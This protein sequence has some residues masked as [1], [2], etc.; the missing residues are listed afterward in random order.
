MAQNVADTSDSGAATVGGLGSIEPSL[1][2]ALPYFLA[3][4]IFPLVI[5]A[6]IHGGWWL[7]LPLAFYWIASLFDARLGDDE[8]N[9]D[10]ERTPEDRLLWYKL[11][12]W[13]WAVLWPVT[14][15]FSL[16]QML[17]AG[18][19]AAW[20]IALMAVVLAMVAQSVFI[21]GHEMIHRLS[22][23]ERRFGELLLSSV[24]YPHYTTEHIYIHHALVG[25]PYDVGS[26][27]RGQ[28]FWHYFP[29]E[30]ASNL[31]EAWR[32]Q[33]SRLA[34]R[35]LP[36]WHYSNPFWRYA[37]EVAFWYG[38]IGWMGG[39]WAVAVYAVLCLGVVFS[40]KM[41]NYL[42]HYGLRRIRLPTG[43]FERVQPWHAWSVDRK[44]DNWLFFNMQRHADHHAAA[45]RRYPLMQH[46][47]ADMS[48]QLPGGYGKMFALVLFP[49]RWFETMDPLVDQWRARFY[50]QIEDWSAYDSPAFAARPD[51]FEAI[52]EILGAAPRLG[53]WIERAPELLDNLAKKEFTD[54]D[55]PDGFGPDPEFEA[56]AR[57]GLARVY[58][59]HEL[60]V[61][62]MKEEIADIPV[63]GVREA[64]EVARGWSNGKAFQI[65]V[66]TMRGNLTPVEAG[67]ALSNVAEASIAAV[68]SAVEEA[69]AG[70]AA[71]GGVAAVVLGDLASGEA[72]PGCE[73]DMLFL[74]EAAD[75]G[76]PKRHESLCRAFIEALRGLS[77]DNLL[78]A[79][80][81]PDRKAM[82]VRSFADFPEHHRSAGT[83]AELLDLTR[84]RCVHTSGDG[85]LGERFERARQDVLVHGAARDRLVAEL[86]EAA[87]DA[88]APGPASMED[89]RGGL[90]DVER[91][92][93]FLYMTRAAD[94]ADDTSAASGI[95]ADADASAAADASAT[96][97]A[98][99]APGAASVFRAAGEHGLIPDD[100]AGRLAEAATL[101]R[102]LRGIVRVVAGDGF[103][104]ETA[105]PRIKAVVARACGMDDF[106]AL[107]AAIRNT[108]A[109]TSAD[110]DALRDAVPSR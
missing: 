104:L 3:V 32:V 36:V 110:I 42:Q 19:L 20:E 64:V 108:A 59:T 107:T 55:L 31:T 80:V 38:L 86:C 70:R 75:N 67:K 52:E 50:P 39:A 105:D 61:A 94:A 72:A 57:S 77:R 62:E 49:R 43:K 85:D 84:A 71:G 56:V 90:R 53:R 2:G 89:M 1:R 8:R 60:G 97:N 41:S 18:H 30:V 78:L 29:R 14:F 92:A 48:P 98:S 44:L 63:Q 99:A 15:V 74:H 100:A 11:A 83:P 102:N 88:P 106:G 34:R 23:W 87:A 40:M 51:A 24:S 12:V 17:V 26:A 10:P 33:R 65:A 95:S 81:R 7:A 82:T 13:M 76:S 27:P 58:W 9:M 4:A 5:N 45:G 103:V 47:G 101:W 93:R 37:V 46:R 16:W 35:H 28:S 109:C 79:P 91:A 25:T 69:F 96:A 6:A 54:L 21:A 66:H 22:V 68:L 73:L